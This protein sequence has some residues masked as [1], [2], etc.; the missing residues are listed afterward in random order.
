MRNLLSTFVLTTA[1]LLVGAQLN[2]MPAAVAPQDST[3]A[4]P[5]QQAQGDADRASVFTGKV[6]VA[7]GQYVLYV[8]MDNASKV[9]YVL[10]DQEKAKPFKGKTVKV[11]GTLETASNTIHISNI[12][13]A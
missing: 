5:P 1:L 3:Q 4:Q 11:T 6:M 8:L 9:T 13:P 7:K 12:E 10:D 2:A